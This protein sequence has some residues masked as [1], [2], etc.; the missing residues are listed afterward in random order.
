MSDLVC[1]GV[2]QSNIGAAEAQLASQLKTLPKKTRQL[3]CNKADIKQ[4]CQI[5]KEVSLMLKGHVKLS[6][7]QKRKLT[8]ILRVLRV[9]TESDLA[10]RELRKGLIDDYLEGC[11]MVFEFRDED[12]PQSVNRLIGKKAPCVFIKNLPRLSQN[13]STSMQMKTNWSGMNNP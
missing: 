6:W 3:V 9:K 1:S 7:A 10:Q 8:M 11:N 12:D 2:K 5:T 13:I 4:R